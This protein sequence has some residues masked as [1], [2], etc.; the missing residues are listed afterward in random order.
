MTEAQLQTL[1]RNTLA[2]LGYTVIETGKARRKVQCPRCKGWHYPTGWQG[3]T[4]GCPDLYVHAQHWRVPVAVGIELKT[5]KGAVR[6]EQKN[7]AGQNMTAICRDLESVVEV[8]RDYEIM[9]GSPVQTERLDRF[10]GKNKR[11][12]GLDVGAVEVGD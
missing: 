2:V 10:L 6:R 5:T 3:N 8:L 7:M 9:Y 4:P 12:G 11:D 1:V